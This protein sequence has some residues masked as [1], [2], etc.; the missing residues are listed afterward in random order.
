MD[1][2]F[3]NDFLIIDTGR[4]SLGTINERAWYITHM[5][6]HK[7]SVLGCQ[8]RYT[9]RVHPIVHAVTKANF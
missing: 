1:G 4:G 6:N 2:N 7:A 8:D 3:G 5:T 9:P